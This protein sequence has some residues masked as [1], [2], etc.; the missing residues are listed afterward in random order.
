M[1][2]HTLAD[3]ESSGEEQNGEVPLGRN[4]VTPNSSSNCSDD[5][6]GGYGGGGA[7]RHEQAAADVSEEGHDSPLLGA[8]WEL[9]PDVC[10]QHVLLWLGDRDR[11]RASLVCRRWH[12]ATR[13]PALWRSRHFRF[14]GRSTNRGA[15]C[16]EQERADGY[17]R[18]LGS[19]LEELEVLVVLP[20]R[21]RVSVVRRLQLTLKA[22]FQGVCSSGA[23]LRSLGVRNLQLHREAWTRSTR[24]NIVN[25]LAQFLG[26]A[27]THLQHLSLWGS[28]VTLT[29]GLKI[30]RPLA[31]AQQYLGG[32]GGGGGGGGILSLDLE[33]FFA[34]SE[35]VH[36]HPDFPLLLGHFHRL[37]WLSLSYSCVSDELLQ[38]L[39]ASQRQGQGGKGYRCGS[40]SSLKC[41]RLKCHNE[42]PHSQVVR[43]IQ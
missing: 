7:L 36:N 2:L 15:A 16:M 3:S 23:R 32:K 27:S 17:M 43:Y 5:D 40:R 42:E 37:E 28:R 25:S 33:G 8:R 9:L 4:A 34:S 30:L 24:S 38:A 26:H 19:F 10:L 22:L 20:Y 13:S 41:L 35:P 29:H 14:T 12:R 11:T 21:S 18:T 39:G 31:H 6:G 1:S